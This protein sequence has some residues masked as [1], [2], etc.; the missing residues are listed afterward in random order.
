MC[1]CHQIHKTKNLWSW[2]GQQSNMVLCCFLWC[3]CDTIGCVLNNYIVICVLWKKKG[4]LLQHHLRHAQFTC[5]AV[6]RYGGTVARRWKSGLTTVQWVWTQRSSVEL[7]IFT[8]KNFYGFRWPLS[9]CKIEIVIWHHVM[10]SCNFKGQYL[11]QTDCVIWGIC[12]VFNGPT[13]A[14]ES[15]LKWWNG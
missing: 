1:Y 5:V 9:Q 2:Q 13:A 3:K 8:K 12:V 4:K 14:R 7:R 11:Y 6:K 15:I 10:P